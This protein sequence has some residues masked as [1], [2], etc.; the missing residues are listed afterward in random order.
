M[1]PENPNESI[2]TEAPEAQ[3]EI[4]ELE[5]L[6][7]ENELLQAELKAAKDKYIRLYADF[8]NYRKRMAVE[9][10]EAQRSGKFEAI[11]ALLPALDDLER[12]LGFA[13][14]KPEELLPGVKS[15]LENFRRN[16]GSLGV[17][18][19]AGVGAEFDPR[20]H[21][22][23]GA[24]EGEE[25]KVL[26]VYQQGF[27]YGEMLVRPARVVVGSGK[28]PEAEGQPTSADS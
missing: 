13:Q 8:D 27:K 17:E 6:K 4:S 15:V 28:A 3:A 1:K 9:L 5:R 26:H 22:A 20:Y 23:I 24:V 25:G 7:G 10:A 16:L 19:V 14:A 11:R 21:E 2:Q 18:P 12:A